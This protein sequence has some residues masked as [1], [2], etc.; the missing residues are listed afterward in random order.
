MAN[1]VTVRQLLEAGV[2]FGHKTRRWNPKMARYIYGAHNG[3]HII[4]L[5]KSMVCIDRAMSTLKE[6]VKEGGRVLFVGTKIQ[7]REA[8]KE[9]AQRSG[10]YYVNHRW[11]G[12]TLTNWKTVSQSI[13]QLVLLREQTE[14]PNF[15]EYTKKEQLRFHRQLQRLELNLGGIKDMG[16]LPDV[17]F[18]IDTNKEFIAV[19]EANRLKIP[20]IAV[21]DTNSK[22]DAI[23]Y[24]IPGNDDAI[25][26]VHLYCDLAAK[27]IIEGLQAEMKDAGVDVGDKEEVV[28]E[29]QDQ[30]LES[31]KDKEMEKQQ[32]A[33]TEADVKS[34]E[35]QKQH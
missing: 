17:L 24:P 9:A 13:H 29:E 15:A 32:A 11:L 6:I 33:A 8:I 31:F 18:V 4:D 22:P 21:I 23:D 30:L 28:I 20:V 27:A 34:E 19:Q 3:V 12:G 1:I 16:G 7:A 26:A 35:T 2:H 25:K 10:Q 14:S 5:P